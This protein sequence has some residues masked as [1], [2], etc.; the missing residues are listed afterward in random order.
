MLEYLEL[1]S[2]EVVASAMQLLDAT[3]SEPPSIAIKSIGALLFI[4]AA[5]KIVSVLQA[6]NSLRSIQA[7]NKEQS[8]SK[9]H[10]VASV[11]VQNGPRQ[12]NSNVSQDKKIEAVCSPRLT[13]SRV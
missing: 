10:E 8:Y 1:R 7:A 3:Y 5:T 9:K 6:K 4:L 12:G 2:R 11:K 13:R